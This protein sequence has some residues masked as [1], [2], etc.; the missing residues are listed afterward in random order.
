MHHD[1]TKM[2]LNLRQRQP[3]NNKTL[4]SGTDIKL[5]KSVVKCTPVLDDVFYVDRLV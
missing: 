4:N 5:E 3:T 1:S 2:A